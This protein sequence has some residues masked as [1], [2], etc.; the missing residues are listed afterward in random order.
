MTT[1]LRA[2]TEQ[3]LYTIVDMCKRERNSLPAFISEQD[4]QEHTIIIDKVMQEL[5]ARRETK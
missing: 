5:E 4:A 3:E 1:A 2:F